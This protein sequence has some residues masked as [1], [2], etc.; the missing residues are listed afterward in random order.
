MTTKI[1]TTGVC[2]DCR[3]YETSSSITPNRVF[4]RSIPLGRGACFAQ[5]YGSAPEKEAR[6]VCS[7]ERD[8]VPLYRA[9][10]S[11]Q[12]RTLLGFNEPLVRDNF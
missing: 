4:F 7:E 6:S 12:V 11:H 5:E 9:S 10:L 1:E 8:G 2:A 3:F